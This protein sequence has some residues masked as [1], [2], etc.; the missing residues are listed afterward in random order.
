MGLREGAHTRLDPPG[1]VPR[2][3]RRVR[4]SHHATNQTTVI[5]TNS[6]FDSCYLFQTDYMLLAVADRKLN[7]SLFFG[8]F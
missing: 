4:V 7:L 1:G 8:L 2:A 5:Q 3:P 6:H